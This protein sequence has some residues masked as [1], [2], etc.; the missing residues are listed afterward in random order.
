MGVVIFISADFEVDVVVDAGVEVDVDWVL[1]EYSKVVH[2]STDNNFKYI[3]FLFIIK[4]SSNIY[5]NQELFLS[6]Y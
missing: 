3:D 5:W 2:K 4:S 6:L 1:Q